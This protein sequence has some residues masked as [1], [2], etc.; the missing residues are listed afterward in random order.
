MLK[1]V[2]EG[3]APTL[4]REASPEIQKAIDYIEQSDDPV[5]KRSLQAYQEFVQQSG[6]HGCAAMSRGRGLLMSVEN[7]RRER[8][9]PSLLM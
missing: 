2:H 3:G 8:G 6:C 4:L 7:H 5:L 1:T 9:L